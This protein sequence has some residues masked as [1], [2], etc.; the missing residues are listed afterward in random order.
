MP[1]GAT[2]TIRDGRVVIP[3]HAE[4]KRKLRGFIMDESATGQTVYIEPAESLE[5]N[6]EIRDLLHA[7]RREVVRILKE[8]TSVL[9]ENLQSI[10][11]AVHF[12][13]LIDFN[14]AKA[15]LAADMEADMPLISE[16]PS[17]NWILARHPLLCI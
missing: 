3:V 9:R 11:A 5:A 7:D 1:E 2:L 14:R 10:K 16:T 12:L 15:K 4:Y 17:L 8:L 6:N 13:G